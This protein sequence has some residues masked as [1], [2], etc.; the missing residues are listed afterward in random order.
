M[1]WDFIVSRAPLFWAAAKLTV[2]LAVG[3][4]LLAAAL[5]FLCAV[6]RFYRIPVFNQIAYF[7]IELARNTPLMVQLFF[8]YFGLPRLGLVWEGQT[9]AIVGLTFL[10]GAYMAE[11]FRGGLAAINRNQ[12][13]SALSIGLSRIQTLRYVIA[14]QALAVA[15]PA[16]SATVIF[17]MKETS[18][19]SIVALPDLMYVAKD[20]LKEGHS[21]E[22]NL[23]LILSYLTIILPVSLFFGRMERRLRFAGFG[24]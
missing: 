11:A 19:F 15:W 1:D 5:G 24:S 14:P 18:V 4:I 9:C 8:L 13:E 2:K 12:V 23:L 21:G 7:Y 22:T 17:L 16:I 6:A 20:L 10:G 3:G